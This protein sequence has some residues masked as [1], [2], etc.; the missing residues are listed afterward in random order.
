MRRMPGSHPSA[1]AAQSRDATASPVPGKTTRVESIDSAPSASSSSHAV[2]CKDGAPG[3]GAH[4]IA[5]AGVASGGGPLPFGDRIQGLF[6]RHDLSGVRAHT[7]GAAAHASTA[8][9]ATAYARGNAIAFGGAPDLH[10]AAHEAAHVVQQRGGVQL[11]GGVGQVGDVHERH[12]DAVADRVVAGQSAE[13]LLDDVAPH[14]GSTAATVAVQR[15]D[16]PRASQGKPTDG[17]APAPSIATHPSQLDRVL[18]ATAAHDLP[19]LIA[20]QRDLRIEIAKNAL[21]PPRDV[22]DALSTARH[23]TM[24]RIAEI[25]DTY[26]P[27]TAAVSKPAAPT[28]PGAPASP[29]AATDTSGEVE[30]YEALMDAECTPYLDALME[31]HAEYRYEHFKLDV[32]DKVFAAVRLHA[33]RRA[34]GRIGHR[35]EA[36]TEARTQGA[37]PSGAWCGAFAYT[38][39]EGGGFDPRWRTAMQG[40]AMIRSMLLY[41][42]TM[43]QTWIWAFDHWELLKDYHAQRNSLRYYETIGKGPPTHGIQAGDLI[44]IDNNFGTDP[45]HITTAVS[46]DGRFLRTVGGNQGSDRASDESGVSRNAPVDL[47]NNPDPN[48]VTL[49][50]TGED[51]KRK[52]TADPKKVKNTRVH[53]VGRW[54]VVDYERRL[55]RESAAKP[56]KPPTQAEVAALA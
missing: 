21:T 54:S 15:Q 27:Q 41:L 50:V 31:G 22:R 9:G 46:F 52:K 13:A 34:V 25:R 12:A 14:G 5:D 2:Q 36:E 3:E 51:G 43:A 8:L 45:D 16:D 47:M 4:A 1:T 7:D 6:G 18:G 55:Y 44:L 56:T 20:I 53:G 32:A 49:W 29:S 38:Q 30:V 11:K 28:A 35:A 42:G 37:L 23:W 26:A 33:A 17:Q 40:E 39:A 10:T 24:D 19:G 48:D